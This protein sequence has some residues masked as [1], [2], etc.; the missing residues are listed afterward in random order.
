VPAGDQVADHAVGGLLPPLQGLAREAAVVGA[1]HQGADF[2]DVDQ[3]GHAAAFA[4]ELPFVGELA[5]DRQADDGLGPAAGLLGR[6]GDGVLAVAGGRDR[7][8]A[9]EQAIEEG[10]Q[11]RSGKQV[12][13]TVVGAPDPGRDEAGLVEQDTVHPGRVEVFAGFEPRQ[14]GGRGLCRRQGVNRRSK[15]TG[16]QYCRPND[17]CRFRGL[18]NANSHL[19]CGEKDCGKGLGNQ[20]ATQTFEARFGR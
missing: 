20:E 9:S 15:L 17:R 14:A 13:S 11:V 16:G 18:Q 19:S 2:L 3:E 5:V 10:V 8:G 4:G 1:A 12:C 7:G 6:V